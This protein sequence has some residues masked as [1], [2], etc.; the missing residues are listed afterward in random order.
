VQT[1]AITSLSDVD[2]ITCANGRY[3]LSI[4]SRPSVP[5]D[6]LSVQTIRSSVQTN[7]SSV[8][9]NRSGANK[10]L[11]PLGDSLNPP[12]RASLLSAGDLRSAATARSRSL[13]P[14]PN[15]ARLD[16]DF[17]NRPRSLSP[18]PLRS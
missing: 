4:T 7:R 15:S 10:Y 12:P 6:R 18:R 16:P 9:T 3:H 17:R 1:R 14:R 11:A 5:T 2:S 13:S 8:L